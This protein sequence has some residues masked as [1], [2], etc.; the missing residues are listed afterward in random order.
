VEWFFVLIV[1]LIVFGPIV[2]AVTKGRRSRVPDHDDADGFT[3]S[4]EF[5]RDRLA[6]PG[7]H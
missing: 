3:A 1:V 6:P 2:W 4:E 5:I 7:S